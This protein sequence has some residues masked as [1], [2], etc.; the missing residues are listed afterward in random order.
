MGSLEPSGKPDPND[1]FRHALT[2]SDGRA[3]IARAEAVL[4]RFGTSAEAAENPRSASNDIW[5][6]SGFCLRMSRR[7]GPDTLFDEARLAAALPP[8]VGYPEIL[9]T[10][11]EAGYQWVLS[12]R[13]PGLNLWDAWPTMT[14]DQRMTAIEDLWHRHLAL[15][16]ANP[17][18]L[19]DLPL[20]PLRRY[21]FDREESAGQLRRLVGA[22]V[23]DEELAPSLWEIV[24]RGLETARSVPWRLVHGDPGLTNAQCHDGVVIGLL[25]LEAACIAPFDLDLDLLMRVLADPLDDSDSPGPYGMP[26]E[27]SFTG[28]FE[29]LVTAAAPILQHPGA[30]DRFRCYAVLF[31]LTILGSALRRGVPVETLRGWSARIRGVATHRSHLDC[32]WP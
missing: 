30:P 22:G 4:H 32:I 8:E 9:A 17:K 20:P 6:V 11:V 31:D 24:E 15:Q 26:D 28:A 23:L 2:R 18:L 14:H 7:S 12:R 3:A 13:L 25:D 27:D 21:R 1:R 16:E 29:R 19:A 5:L 10:G